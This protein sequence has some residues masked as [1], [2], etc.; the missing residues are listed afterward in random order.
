[1]KTDFTEVN[2]D[3]LFTKG[4]ITIPEMDQL[5]LANDLWRKVIR[6]TKQR[7]LKEQ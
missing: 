3:K 6:R 2:I 4:L 1:M 5:R 7:V